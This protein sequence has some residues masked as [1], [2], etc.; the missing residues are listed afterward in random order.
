LGRP[1]QRRRAPFEQAPAAQA[2]EA[3]RDLPAQAGS[4][5]GGEHQ[6]ERAH[7]ARIY[8]LNRRSD[9][10]FDL[11][12]PLLLGRGQ[13]LDQERAGVLEELALA[14]RQLLGVLQAQQVAQHLGGLEDGADLELVLELAELAAPGDSAA[15]LRALALLQDLPDPG[16]LVA[17]DR[18]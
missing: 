3:L 2:H 7:S 17:L 8:L 5:A 10:G 13:L 4:L 18:R 6:G 1:R 14:E 9:R 15:R 12:G 16:R 11:V